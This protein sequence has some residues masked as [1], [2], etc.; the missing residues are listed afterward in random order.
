MTE[1]S[2]DISIRAK[3]LNKFFK[4][5]GVLL[6][7]LIPVFLSVWFRAYTYYLP[8]TDEW[9]KQSVHSTIKESI[10]SQIEAKYPDLLDEN[11]EIF[12]EKEFQKTIKGQ[13]SEINLQI[14]SAS[15]YFKSALKDDRGH[16]YLADIDSYTWYEQANN[17]LNNGHVGDEIRDGKYVQTQRNGRLG[18]EVS[19]SLTPLI[20]VYIYKIVHFFNK[21][22]SMMDAAFA[23]PILF[24]T[25]SII[26][27]FLIGRKI[28]GN[29]GGLFAGG[30]IA[31]N[32]ALMGRTAAGFADTD[33]NQ[34]LFPLLIVWMFVEAVSAKGN[35]KMFFAGLTG[36]FIG[37]YAIT[38]DAGWWF[39]FDFL[40]ATVVINIIYS[41]YINRKEIKNGG[42]FKNNLIKNELIMLAVLIA[43]SF[44]FSTL[45]FA[46]S[47][48]ISLLDSADTFQDFYKGPIGFKGMK[49]VA[50]DKIWPN[51]LTT[52]AEFNEVDTKEII[53]A[54]GGGI[55]FLIAVAGIF[56]TLLKK[57]EK[58]NREIKYFILMVIWFI[59]TV[60]A[61]TKG[62]RFAILMVPAF[63][64]A[65]GAAVGIS[66]NYLPNHLNKKM[67]I[68]PYISKIAIISVMA[69]LFIAPIKSAHNTAKG[70]IPNMNDALY[71]SLIKIKE[72]ST[73]AIIT[74]WWD[75]GHWFVA[76][77]D[78]RVTFDGGDQGR[79]IHWVGKALLTSSEE[80]SV[81]ILR[82]LNCKQDEAYKKLEE[83][84]NDTRT[85]VNLIYNI[86]VEDKENAR[87]IL[88]ENFIDE[89][90]ID[91]I[92]EMTHCDNL[93]DQYF[94]ASEDMV[95]KSGVWGHFG[96]W[97]FRKAS[98]YSAV[99][100]KEQKEGIDIL[101]EKFGKTEN[102]A[103]KIYSE[104]Q[105][106]QGDQWIAGWPGYRSGIDSCETLPDVIRCNNGLMFNR[107]TN[108]AFFM[109]QEGIKY[110]ESFVYPV[111]VENDEK[112]LYEVKYEKDTVPVSAV[113]IKKDSGGF[114]S[115]LADKELVNSI[116][117]KL[118]Y[119]KGR[120]LK[121]FE[122]FDER[123]QL[124]GQRIYV[125]K[126]NF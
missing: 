104:I 33:A 56:L 86:V 28:A 72:N 38:W 57:D 123:M 75:F 122:L 106:T 77:S 124:N 37:V 43:S 20:E 30:I 78:R 121:H 22:F 51:V 47:Q 41:A 14:K 92:L 17:I 4:R 111:E 59:S 94:I 44:I 11:K 63:A 119:H 83:K 90:S 7:I 98:M 79:R 58:E 31:V 50:T 100:G 42:L 88:R 101:K 66:Y 73:D 91:E 9:A 19:F 97:D 109:T 112:K 23:F 117:T 34:A 24:V 27:A 107:T 55:M 13:K 116:F 39:I 74:S 99:R 71:D 102:E 35:K 64:I 61:F 70:E 105:E 18:K 68:K 103:S 32:S 48:K 82:M 6:L 12:I 81:G 26:P 54:M 15:E 53:N 69:L 5:Y 96:S 1:K 29:L 62:I 125:Y 76:I 89:E 120:G 87:K 110:P 67:N 16:T 49:G 80:E 93:I 25:L 126:V 84:T 108:T 60:Y 45:G 46:Y 95:G 36:L 65:F 118:F 8:I 115:V 113:L 21:D 10:R 40:I 2:G 3:E 52:V 85:S 114:Q